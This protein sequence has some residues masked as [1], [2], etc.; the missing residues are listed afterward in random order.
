[1]AMD[2][3]DSCQPLALSFKA[4]GSAFGLCQGTPSD[5]PHFVRMMGFSP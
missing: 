1:M 2:F 5:V 3:M 4:L